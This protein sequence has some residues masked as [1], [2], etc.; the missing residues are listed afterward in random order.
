MFRCKNLPYRFEDCFCKERKIKNKNKQY[1][2]KYL[3]ADELLGKHNIFSKKLERFLT[4]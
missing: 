4:F 2:R 3:Q 1:F